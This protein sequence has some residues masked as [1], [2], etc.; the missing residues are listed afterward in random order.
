MDRRRIC[1]L[2]QPTNLFRFTRVNIDLSGQFRT[3]LLLLGNFKFL[4]VNQY[5]YDS[6]IKVDLELEMRRKRRV[7]N[8][9]KETSKNEPLGELKR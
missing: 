7:K 2:F 9:E 4:E 8:F 1:F 6:Y 5:W 3:L